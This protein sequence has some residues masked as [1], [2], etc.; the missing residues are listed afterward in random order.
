MARHPEESDWLRAET[1]ADELVHLP[2][3]KWEGEF[4]RLESGGEPEFILELVRGLL[5]ERP[6]RPVFQPGTTV[7]G[8]TLLSVLGEGSMG[9]VWRARQE[10]IER[11]VA[12]KVIHT[13]L[14]SIDRRERFLRE[15]QTLGKLSHPGIVQIY[16]AGLFES[17]GNAPMPF[18]TMELIEGL[19]LDQWAANQSERPGPLLRVM[20][21]VCAAVQYAHDRRIVHRDLKPA[22]ILVRTDGRPV[23]LDFGIAR[24]VGAEMKD[25]SGGFEGTPLYAAPE[26]FLGREAGSP[27]VLIDQAGT[28]KTETHETFAI[29]RVQDSIGL[30]LY[31]IGVI[32]FEQLSGRFPFDIQ[33]G[34]SL[35]SIRQAKMEGRMVRLREAWPECPPLLDEIIS[36]TIRREAIDRVYSTVAELGRALDTAASRLELDYST[37]P[38]WRPATEAFI[39]RTHWILERK[40]GVGGAGEVW[41][42]RHEQLN[43]QRVFKFCDT[44]EKARTL[45]R[46]LTVYR[47][48]RERIGR[49]PHFVPLVEVSLAEPPWYLMME[50]VDAVDLIVWCAAIPGGLISLPIDDRIEIIAQVAEALQAAHEAGILHRDLKPAN[51]LVQGKPFDEKRRLHVLIADFGI[52]QIVAD[53][54]IRSGGPRSGFTRTVSELARSTISGTL[55]YLAP[56]V[57]GGQA[58]TARSDIY[59]LGIIFWQLLVGNFE[60]GLYPLDW[61]AQV[62]DGH[63]R[64]DLARC[65]AGKPEERWASAGELAQNLRQ[66]PQRRMAEEMRRKATELGERRAYWRGVALTAGFATLVI[67]LF[68]LVSWQ[69]IVQRRSAEQRLGENDIQRLV[70][71]ERTELQAG[72]RKKGLELWKQASRRATNTAALRSTAAIVLGLSDLEPKSDHPER[73]NY[74]HHDGGLLDVRH[75]EGETARASSD[76]GRWLAIAS[77]RNGIDGSVELVDLSLHTTNLLQWTNFPWMP[78]GEPGLL[79]FS[80]GTDRLAI[81]GGQTSRNLLLI[82]VP[83]GKLETFLFHP[84][85]PLSCAWHPGG[86]LLATGNEDHTILLWDTHPMTH[87]RQ[88]G[89]VSGGIT[90]PPETTTPAIDRPI[91][92]LR[93]HRY[94]V[95]FLSFS[96]DGRWLVSIDSGGVLQIHPGLQTEVPASQPMDGSNAPE[97][98]I[99]LMDEVLAEWN[100]QD[101]T[102]IA[103]VSFH[104]DELRI[105]RESGKEDS[106]AFLPKRFPTEQYV[107]Q[108]VNH[109]AWTPKGNGLCVITSGDILWMD[110]ET[111]SVQ[112]WQANMNVDDVVTDPTSGTLRFGQVVKV[113]GLGNATGDRLRPCLRISQKMHASEPE[114]IEGLDSFE[115]S[116]Q[117]ILPMLGTDDGR[118]AIRVGRQVA[119]FK[120]DTRSN[121]LKVTKLGQEG[122][123]VLDWF[124]DSHGTVFGMVLGSPRHPRL[125]VWSAKGTWELPDF[126]SLHGIGLRTNS[127]VVAANDGIHVVIRNPD[128]GVAIYRPKP[129][130]FRVI[131]SSSFARQ[132]Q[133]MAASHDGRFLAMVSDSHRIRL[134]ELPTGRLFAEFVSHRRAPVRMVGWNA[135][136]QQLASVT[137][138]GYI[139]L[140]A[141]SEWWKLLA[142][143]HLLD[144]QGVSPSLQ[145]QP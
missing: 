85:D 54:A 23:V 29:G 28:K 91:V 30:D 92:I 87:S 42:G 145:G 117:D 5:T 99:P 75:T 55:F 111:L 7:N 110:R 84:S 43:V 32:L 98:E 124:W 53:E 45:R 88:D 66:L 89:P 64:S 122:D 61:E 56:E 68:A 115:V 77:D 119:F 17:P 70:N 69:A 144:E 118:F 16:G 47:L 82:K 140:W 78:I 48:L 130:D 12:L 114:P 65:L 71:F 142:D 112:D 100:I 41:L 141:L 132:K 138:D 8:Y 139:Q 26:Q 73:T 60:T 13:H 137:E 120:G 18:F 108:G 44:E 134:L 37:P 80:P 116:R 90:L 101:P 14:F 102:T 59:S 63:V 34:A 33:T 103:Q 36:R 76:N 79:R 129:D 67:I 121:P 51:L 46:E 25:A 106:F 109:V 113:R 31:A 49:N 24:L 3:E 107:N 72:R 94:P 9:T 11:E 93:S 20:A 96:T 105:T 2:A 4:A 35:W 83:E 6:S 58:A 74:L 38:P 86:R 128:Q 143:H 95:R 15:M 39:P 62:P 21:G 133:P 136:S 50:H 81:G 123:V 19:P 127:V 10:W 40:I 1:L 131:D 135:N 57:L 22:N 27:P 125:N 52:G 97:I 104:G 126:T